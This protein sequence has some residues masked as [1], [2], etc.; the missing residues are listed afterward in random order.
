VQAGLIAPH[1]HGTFPL[2]ETADALHSS[3]AESHRKVIVN[4]QH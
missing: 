1:I 3:R 4:P 2:V